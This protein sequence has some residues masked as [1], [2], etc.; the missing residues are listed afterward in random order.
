MIAE[1][2]ELDYRLRLRVEVEFLR[3]EAQSWIA[4][5]HDQSPRRQDQFFCPGCGERLHFVYGVPRDDDDKP[6]APWGPFA[7]AHNAPVHY[8][9]DPCPN[10]WWLVA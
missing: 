8:R 6:R 7:L 4:G 3:L 2:R 10:D 1:L 9:E 5:W